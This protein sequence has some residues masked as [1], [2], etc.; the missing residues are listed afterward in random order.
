METAEVRRIAFLA[1][2]GI[3]TDDAEG[4]AHDL[5]AILDLVAQLNQIDTSGV[6]PLAHPLEMHQRLRADEITEADQ[7]ERFQA[8]A[9][10][11]DAGLYLVPRVIE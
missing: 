8:G 5:S 6:E 9:P 10:L 4:Y 1:R 2:L 11:T 7:Q 3:A